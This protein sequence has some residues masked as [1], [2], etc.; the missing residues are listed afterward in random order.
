MA[1]GSSL[2][3][4]AAEYYGD[5]IFWVYIYE[6]NKNNIKNFDDIP[7]GTEIQLPTPNTYGIDAKSNSS[8]QKARQKQS[9]LT[10]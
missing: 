3:Q 2:T 9:Q 10:K 1:A 6:H 8:L 5:K 4:I 7:A